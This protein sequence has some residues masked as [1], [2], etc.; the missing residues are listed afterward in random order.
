MRYHPFQRRFTYSVRLEHFDGDSTSEKCLCDLSF[1]ALA[2][3]DQG[4][5]HSQ[6]GSLAGAAYL[7]NN[8]T[9]VLRSAQ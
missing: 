8:N 3:G 4:R 2:L 6:M 7:L 5:R 1:G 9:S